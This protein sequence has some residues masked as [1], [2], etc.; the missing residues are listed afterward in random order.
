MRLLADRHILAPR[1]LLVLLRFRVPCDDLKFIREDVGELGTVAVLSTDNLL[2]ALFVVARGEEMTEDE[3]R[4]L[5]L[6]GRMLFHRDTVTIVLHGD[7]EA[8]IVEAG[9]DLNVLDRRAV[10][11]RLRANKSITSIDDQLIKGLVKTRIELDLTMNHLILACIIDPAVFSAS[12]YRPD[13]RVRKLK[14]VRTVLE[15]LV[16]RGHFNLLLKGGGQALGQF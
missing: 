16:V 7:A 13:V 3:L 11:I 4:D 9:R 15:L 1:L 8:T 5:A 10:G 14:N 12:V 2:F 6:L